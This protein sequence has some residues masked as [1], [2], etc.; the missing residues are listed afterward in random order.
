VIDVG[1]ESRAFVARTA[2]TVREWLA[3]PYAWSPG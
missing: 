2:G 3:D 1:I